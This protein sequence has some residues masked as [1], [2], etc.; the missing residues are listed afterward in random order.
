MCKLRVDYNKLH[1][2]VSQASL[3]YTELVEALEGIE[4]QLKHAKVA[5][6]IIVHVVYYSHDIFTS[7]FHRLISKKVLISRDGQNY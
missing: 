6:P 2:E 5:N 4:D 1:D 3:R 7:V